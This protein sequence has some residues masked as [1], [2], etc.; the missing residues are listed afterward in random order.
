MM[1]HPLRWL[2]R[3]RLTPPTSKNSQKSTETFQS[4]GDA[5][6]APRDYS[7]LDKILLP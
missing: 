7:F 5:Q 2:H 3:L 4:R 1:Q 6:R